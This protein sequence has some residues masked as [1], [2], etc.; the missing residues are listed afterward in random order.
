MLALRGRR[1][2]DA[3]LNLAVAQQWLRNSA[4]RTP[5]RSRTR[6]NTAR[7]WSMKQRPT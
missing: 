7:G 5:G 1:G 4:R 3:E 2:R 6:P